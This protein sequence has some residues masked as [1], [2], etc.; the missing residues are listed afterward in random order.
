MT[1][2]DRLARAHYRTDAPA[3]RKKGWITKDFK[4]TEKGKAEV[5]RMD[6]KKQKPTI[7]GFTGAF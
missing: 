6:K 7:Y 3:M 5:K 4:V 2:S 1:W